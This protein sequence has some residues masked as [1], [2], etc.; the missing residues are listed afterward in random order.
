MRVLKNLS[1]IKQMIVTTNK[2]V[3]SIAAA[4]MTQHLKWSLN[5]WKILWLRNMR[6]NIVMKTLG[7]KRSM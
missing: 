2:N 4:V 3:N 6:Q 1:Q 5:H 7:V